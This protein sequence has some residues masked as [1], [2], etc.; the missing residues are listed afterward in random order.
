MLPALTMTGGIVAE[1]LADHGVTY[2]SVDTAASLPPA[3]RRPLEMAA[4]CQHC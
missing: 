4:L 3:D 1:A 2:A